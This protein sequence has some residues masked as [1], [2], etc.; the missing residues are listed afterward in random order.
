MTLRMMIPNN[1]GRTILSMSQLLICLLLVCCVTTHGLNAQGKKDK[2]KKD[3][4]KKPA[5]KKVEYVVGKLV[6]TN[7]QKIV[8]DLKKAKFALA[9]IVE[10]ENPPYPKDFQ[11]LPLEKQEAWIKDFL[12]SK[13]GI[14]Y[15]ARLRKRNQARKIF[16]I[17]FDDDGSFK[18]K[19]VPFGSYSLE[20]ILFGKSGDKKFAAEVIAGVEIKTDID[21][22]DLGKIEVQ[23]L[24]FLTT[25]DAAPEIEL[26]TIDGKKVKL[27]DYRGKY[28]LIDFWATWC[29]PCVAATPTLK[30]IYSKMKSKGK[31]EVIGVSLDDNKEKPIKYTKE[32][33]I[34]WIQAFAGPDWDQKS[35]SGWGVQSIPSF[36]LVDPKGKIIVTDRDFFE[37]NLDLKK[38]IEDKVK[39]R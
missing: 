32:K 4:D 31:F 28:V 35:I 20:G 8:P 2:Q 14:A 21:Q 29:V 6:L 9:E 34:K 10:P 27:S 26:G 17:Y 38:V 33:Q 25:G 3:K 36:W 5:A 13:A 37:A 16:K 12:E 22:V 18:V 39:L 1:F 11:K 24:P 19:N 15:K 30:E 7:K 23:M